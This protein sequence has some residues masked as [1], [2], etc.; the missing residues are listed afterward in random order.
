MRYIITLVIVIV[1]LASCKTSSGQTQSAVVPSKANDFREFKV[2]D[3]YYIDKDSLFN[4][5]KEWF[6]EYTDIDSLAPYIIEKSIPELQEQVYNRT[7]SYRDITIFYLHRIYQYDRQNAAS[8]NSVISINPTAIEDAIAYDIRMDEIVQNQEPFDVNSLMGMPI[9]IKDNINV[10]GMPTTAGAVALKDNHTENAKMIDA[11]ISGGAI[12]LGKANLSE[13]AYYFCGDCP[14]G[15]SAIGGQTLNPYGRRTIDTGGSSSGSGASVAANFAVAAIGSETAGS[16]LSPS[17]QH[18]LVGYKPSVGMVSGIGII[19]ISNYLD[20]AGPM[21]KFVI[22][23]AIVMN[24]IQQLPVV[25]DDVM[26]SLA[27]A[28]LKGVRLGYFQDFIQV[29]GFEKA[30]NDLTALGALMIPLSARELDLSGFIQLLNVD[31]K[32]DL[33]SYF[34]GQ[35]HSDFR[36]WDVQKVIDFNVSQDSL[37]VMPYGQRLFEG[38]VNEASISEEHIWSLKTKLSTSAQDYFNFYQ[39]QYN[40]DGFV[41]VNNYSAAAAAVAHFPAMT[42]SMGYDD[43]GVPYG[44]TFIAPNE[45]DALL[46]VWAQAYEQATK[47][48]KFPINYPQ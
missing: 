1:G 45:E 41:S 10:K 25:T 33:P 35:A 24:A 14:S 19:P 12:V 42:V 6:K 27:N 23:N 38:I 47:H 36:T 4:P 26:S 2:L 48:R 40:L 8:L 29:P 44:L 21:T 13:W 22:D 30:V 37:K 20:T 32:R 11:L 28:S 43:K 31:M 15:Y 3:S 9:L 17:S 18:S 16:I 39:Q 7:L 34:L 46:F 5:F